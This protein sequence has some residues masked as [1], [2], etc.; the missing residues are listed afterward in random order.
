MNSLI[1]Y[2]PYPSIRDEQKKILQVFNDSFATYRYFILEAPTGTGKSAIAYT[3]M[4]NV[5][6]A[7][8]ITSSKHLQDQYKNEFKNLL[9]I[10]GKAAYDCLVTN[11][12]CDKGPCNVDKTI[13]SQCKQQCEYYY[14]VNQI[15]RSPLIVTNYSAFLSNPVLSSKCYDLVILDEA[16][17][18]ESNLLKTVG[19]SINIEKLNDDFDVLNIA[20]VDDMIKLSKKFNSGYKQNKEQLQLIY[21]LLVRQQKDLTQQIKMNPKDIDL[22]EKNDNLLRYIK[23]L[24]YFFHASDKEDWVIE[25]DKDNV[26]N[27][28]PINIGNLFYDKIVRRNNKIVCMSATILNARLF[29][30]DLQIPVGDTKCIRVKSTFNPKLAPIIYKPCGR[31]N[32]K[33][34]NNTMPNIVKTV[35]EI[36]DKHKGEKGIIHTNSY[37]ILN[38]IIKQCKN[39]RL[40]YKDYKGALYTMSNEQLMKEHEKSKSDTVLISPSLTTGADL[41]D[42]LSRFQIIVKLPFASLGDK[43][44]AKKSQINPQWYINEMLRTFIQMCGRSIRHDKDYCITYVLDS[45]FEYFIKQNQ[46]LLSDYMKQRIIFKEDEFNEKSYYDFVSQL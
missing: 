37:A 46:T 31:M 10:K 28:Q 15:E 18:L 14:K 27:L 23:R 3:L 7:I 9:N 26:L 36:L 5:K 34:L 42:D 25:P 43:R 22:L 40:L 35:N 13:I 30:N 38:N 16:H 11:C 21:D 8:V 41:K 6:N 4:K 24:N 12:N 20:Q 17:L 39:K 45:S 33:E 29:I 32:Y 19:F 44:V 1:D 2:F